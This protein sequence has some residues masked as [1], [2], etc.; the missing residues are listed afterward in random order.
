[1]LS[2]LKIDGVTIVAEPKSGASVHNFIHCIVV[3]SSNHV[4]RFSLN[5]ND[6]KKLTAMLDDALAQGEKR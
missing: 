3:S 4:V 1:M 2:A 5:E 6:V